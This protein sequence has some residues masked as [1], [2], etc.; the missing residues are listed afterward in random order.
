MNTDDTDYRNKV[1][2]SAQGISSAINAFK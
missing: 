2:H 1:G